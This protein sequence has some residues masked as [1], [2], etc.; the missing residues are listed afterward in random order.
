MFMNEILDYLNTNMHVTLHCYIKFI[1]YN[2]SKIDFD[3]V[4]IWF[5]L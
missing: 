3:T 5:K 2:G 1:Y 4:N